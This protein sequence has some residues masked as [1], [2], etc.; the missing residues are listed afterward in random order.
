MNESDLEAQM[1][2]ELAKFLE[3]DTHGRI[4]ADMILVTADLNHDLK[5]K[6]MKNVSPGNKRSALIRI[7]ALRKHLDA[8]EKK[9]K[10]D[11]A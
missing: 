9:V 2:T 5:P 3:T 1:E 7:D 8:L 11:G 6:D 10:E 4:I